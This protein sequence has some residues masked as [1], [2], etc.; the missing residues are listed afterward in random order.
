MPF[1]NS[2]KTEIPTQKNLT[3][4]VQDQY[5]K[6]YKV[7]FRSKKGHIKIEWKTMIFDEKKLYVGMK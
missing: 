6:N 2:N 3:G 4:N 1:I 5:G 7:V